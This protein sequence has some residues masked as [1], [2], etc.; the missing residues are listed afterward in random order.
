MRTALFLALV[1]MSQLA[2]AQKQLLLL[3]R[4]KVI[5]VFRPGETIRLKR[6]DDENI[7]RSYVNNIFEYAVVLHQD[8]IPFQ[9]IERLYVPE[10]S[11]MN[12]LG[13]MLV[14]GG[15]G[16]FAI[17]Q[18]NQLIQGNGLS[19]DQDISTISLACVGAG[20]PMML[21]RKK[22]QRLRYPYRLL[23]VKLGDP[24]YQR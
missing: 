4:G 22:S 24:L 20:L 15:G 3:K 7:T 11:V 10:P 9:K 18:V 6:T 17:D 21:I 12:K 16:L 1:L 5:H 23:M 8:T 14:V 2:I 19:L 13:G